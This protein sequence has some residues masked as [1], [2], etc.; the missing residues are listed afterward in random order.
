L[1]A[2]E[3]THVVQQGDAGDVVQRDLFYGS[4]YPNPFAGK[5]AE[6][7]AAAQ[8]T[9][10]EWFPSS[11]DFHETATLSGGGK[12]LATL[13]GL[14]TEIGG[15]SA[16]SIT[17][18]DLIGHANADLFALGG[19][20][21]RTS[22]TGSAA[23]TIGATQLAKVQPQIDKVRDR[24]ASGAH[25]TIYGCDSGASGTLLQAISMAFKVCARGFKDPITWCLGWFT[26]PIRIDS[27]GRTLINP[28]DG[29]PC[30][31]YNDSVYNLT[32]DVEDC[33]GTKPK[34]P[35]VVLPPH[36]PVVPSVPE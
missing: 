7:A 24:F 27:R 23:G 4:G 30:T 36:K 5:P 2:H 19:T 35:D 12:G 13:T 29:T 17:D 6:E 1:L 15:K 26:N 3:L 9:P 33:S 18:I 16:G 25:I 34:A 20:I 10:R 14:L 11:V 31:Q 21:T 22:V 32:P 28:K 8:K